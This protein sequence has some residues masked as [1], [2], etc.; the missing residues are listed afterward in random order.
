MVWGKD[1]E[2]DRVEKLAGGVYGAFFSIPAGKNDTL[3]R[4][5]F[6]A[7]GRRSIMIRPDQQREKVTV[8]MSVISDND[9]RLPAM[10]AKRREDVPAQKQ[11]MKE[12]FR[13]AGW[14]C[15]RVVGEMMV[16]KDFYYDMIAQVKMDKWSKG[17][18]VLLGDSG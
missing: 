18:V 5:W 2:Q 1:G 12:Y 4:R 14:E 16:T 13:D 6:H 10:A 11:L 3:W 15:D 9:E 7:A 17:R 8:F